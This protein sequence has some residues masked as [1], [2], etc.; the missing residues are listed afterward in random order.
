MH[1]ELEV[2]PT[3]LNEAYWQV[4]CLVWSL[5]GQGE[6]TCFVSACYVPNYVYLFKGVSL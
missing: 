1:I 6:L 3:V 4:I 5:M 2:T